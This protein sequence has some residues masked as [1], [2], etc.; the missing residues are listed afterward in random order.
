MITIVKQPVYDDFYWMQ[1]HSLYLGGLIIEQTHVPLNLG[2]E[3]N[4]KASGFLS[5]PRT[6]RGAGSTV[7]NASSN[8]LII[9]RNSQQ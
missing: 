4:L 3:G 9:V 6:R 8:Q 7:V 1:I 5:S 2:W